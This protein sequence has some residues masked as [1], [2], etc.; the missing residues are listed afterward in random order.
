MKITLEHIEKIEKSMIARLKFLFFWRGV[1]VY[2]SKVAFFNTTFV[3]G[4]GI[5][6]FIG[7]DGN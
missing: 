2:F 3:I 4:I 5:Y 7:N 6:D 1:S